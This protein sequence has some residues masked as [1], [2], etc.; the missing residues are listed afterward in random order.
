MFWTGG[1]N[2]TNNG[3]GDRRMARR[4]G[5]T[6]RKL[7]TREHVLADLS[8]NCTEKQALLC[9]FSAQRVQP[10]YGIDLMVQTFNRRGEVEPGWLLFQLKGTDR[11]KLVG[12][13]N[14]VS[15][16]VERAHL[17]HWLRQSQPVILVLYDARADVAYWLLVKDYFEALPGFDLA[18]C[19]E[20]V[21]VS[22]PQRNVL[23]RKATR[24]LARRKNEHE[25]T[26][27]R[28]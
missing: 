28:R 24:G 25:A 7:R 21:S 22:I 15:C 14:V 16:R 13:G 6:E 20:R 4:R 12:G 10:D 23:D 18:R 1:S 27:Q 3:R 17:R 19:G 2:G 9:S 8:A 11:V 5:A 26:L